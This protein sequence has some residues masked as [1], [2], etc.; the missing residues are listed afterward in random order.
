VIA[1]V[2]AALL[3]VGASSAARAN[4]AFPDSEAILAPTDRP[5]DII[6][7]TNFGLVTSND[8]GQTWL[9]SC[10]QDGNVLGAF[11]Q[12]T[13]LPRNRLFTVTNQNLGY[14]DDRSCGWQVSGG[15]VAGQSITDAYLDPVSGTRVMAIA[16]ASQI[17]SLFQSTDAGTTFAAALYQAPAGYTMTG[18][19]IA[20][21]DGN[22]V[23]L[24]LRSPAGAPLLAR[25]NDGGAHFTMNDLSASLGTGLL[26][27]IAVDPQ[28]PNRVLMR[29]LGPDDQSIALTVDGGVSA[30]KPVTV[31]G[32]FNSFTRLPSGTIL[33]SGT[34]EYATR[35]GLFR[36]RDRGTTFEMVAS[37]PAIRA[38]AQRAGEVYA[39]ADNFGDGYALGTSMDEG[40]TWQA[41]MTYADVKAINPCLKTA[42]QTTCASLVSVSL[43]TTDVCNA[44]APVTAGTGGSGGAAGAGGRAGSGGSGGSGFAGGAGMP[45]AKHAG[46]D[47]AGS[48]GPASGLGVLLTIACLAV[49]RRRRARDAKPTF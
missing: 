35:P 16:V 15:A 5:Q 26:R 34:V 30:T 9:W 39:A 24:A 28:D 13:P 25:S 23:Y 40:T 48:P 37:P 17:Y 20:Q 21:S 33:I 29:F 42:C 14:S 41:L 6:L 44:V 3:I 27:I 46:C 1:F 45:P 7:V 36:S 4:G 32:D 31:N 18:V 47:V 2:A 19:E 10:E 11:Y 38:L 49:A 43:W 12:L 22:I 8:G